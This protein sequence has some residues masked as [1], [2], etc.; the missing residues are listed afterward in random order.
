M[1][2]PVEWMIFGVVAGGVFLIAIARQFAGSI[3][4]EQGEA[5][6]LQWLPELERTE[7][8][9]DPSIGSTDGIDAGCTE[10]SVR[11]TSV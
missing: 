6:G 10:L 8:A 2:T 7:Q 5:T 3:A 11:L 4:T 1:F 9:S